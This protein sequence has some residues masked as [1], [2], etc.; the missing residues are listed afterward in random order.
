MTKHGHPMVAV[1]MSLALLCALAVAAFAD[2]PK[3][4]KE[5]KSDISAAG[6]A[7]DWAT[8]KRL[9]DEMVADP[10]ATSTDRAWAYYMKV[11]ALA[12][13]GAD[14]AELAEVGKKAFAEKGINDGI[15]ISTCLEVGQAANR[16]KKFKMGEEWL[17]QG[18]KILADQGRWYAGRVTFRDLAVAQAGQGNK[19]EAAQTALEVLENIDQADGKL[20]YY[21]L[22]SYLPFLR[23][24]K[25]P[26]KIL[27]G[28]VL[29]LR[30]AGRTGDL[31]EISQTF[32]LVAQFL[33]YDKEG[34]SAEMKQQF[35]AALNGLEV[36]ASKAEEA[37][38]LQPTAVAGEIADFRAGLAPPGE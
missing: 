8:M 12:R 18:A 24:F 15:K 17:S 21:F 27:H 14:A 9:A 33:V 19:E 7:E 6:S 4:V 30:L 35:I 36:D 31:K 1:A 32:D 10:K 29:A 38:G 34:V 13:E 23:G 16:A 26:D 2:A 3:S 25:D 28:E 11:R 37:G 20:E 22:R 5:L